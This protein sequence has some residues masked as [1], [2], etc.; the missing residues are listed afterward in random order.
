MLFK[1][2]V[3]TVSFYYNTFEIDVYE[4]PHSYLLCLTLFKA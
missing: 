2:A 1:A 4:L 3:L